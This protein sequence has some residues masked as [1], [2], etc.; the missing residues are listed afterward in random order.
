MQMANHSGTVQVPT[1]E[2][3]RHGFARNPMG[4]FFQ[5][6]KGGPQEGGI[7]LFKLVAE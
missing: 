4:G 7:H 1:N 2:I 3:G 5:G 6:N